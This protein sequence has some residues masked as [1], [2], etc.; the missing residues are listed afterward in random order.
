M[1]FLNI[2]KHTLLTM[3]CCKTREVRNSSHSF[4]NTQGSLHGPLG[5]H[6]PPVEKPCF[7]VSLGDFAIHYRISKNGY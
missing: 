1:S 5:V 3:N 2:E 7:R 6:G 4:I